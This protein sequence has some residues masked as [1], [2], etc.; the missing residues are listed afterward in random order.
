ML[1]EDIVGL[2]PKLAGL[3]PFFIFIY[4]AL[5]LWGYF[6]FQFMGKA[7]AEREN[8]AQKSY[9]NGFGIFV[10]I[11]A[12]LEGLFVLDQLCKLFGDFSIFWTTGDWQSFLRIKYGNPTFVLNTLWNNDFWSLM[13]CTVL[14]GLSFLMR[15]LE[16]Y[17]L[18]HQSAPLANACVVL[19]PAHAIVRILQINC[20]EWFGI[21]L[22]EMG[23]VTVIFYSVEAIVSIIIVFSFL[24]VVTLYFRMAKA[25]PSGS[26]LRKKSIQVEIG[27]WVW[28]WGLFSTSL[29]SGFV[30]ALFA[31]LATIPP[32]G[33]LIPF[34]TGTYLII[35]LM[36]LASGM[37]REYV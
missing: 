3:L 32:Y 23:F 22:K 17:M 13:L 5:A 1:F 19:A 35:A 28:L 14:F 20:Y 26:L 15:P 30:E 36:L 10:V 6:G 4:M 11:V 33:Y 29:H 37:R 21:E 8:L 31:N 16:K 27:L 34:T 12:V 25:A 24:V 9:F 2:Y 7:R 18:G